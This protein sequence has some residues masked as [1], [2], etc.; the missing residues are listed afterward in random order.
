MSIQFTSL[1]CVVLNPLIVSSASSELAS[2]PESSQMHR[3]PLHPIAVCAVA[4]ASSQCSHFSHCYV[5]KFCIYHFKCSHLKK[6]ICLYYI[7]W[8]IA[9]NCMN[10]PY[11]FNAVLFV[12]RLMT[13]DVIS[14]SFHSVFVSLWVLQSYSITYVNFKVLY[15]GTENAVIYTFCCRLSLLCS[16][17][18]GVRRYELIQ[19]ADIEWH[20]IQWPMGVQ[21]L[22][23]KVHTVIVGWF[24]GRTW[25]NEVCIT[26]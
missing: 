12:H 10:Y 7:L 21:S 16:I 1:W 23:A 5:V 9:L 17:R 19:M 3:T 15:I 4:A 22:M 24:T 6:F 8:M 11:S 13:K 14:C 18:S 20:V 25:I 26:S 2:V